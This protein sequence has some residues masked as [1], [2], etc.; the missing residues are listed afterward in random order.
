MSNANLVHTVTGDI[1]VANVVHPVCLG[2]VL[3]FLCHHQLA[4]GV[5]KVE[6]DGSTFEVEYTFEDQED[7]YDALGEPPG[8]GTDVFERSMRARYPEI[9]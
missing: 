2:T 3:D 4:Y 9:R 8:A 5:Y 7:F 6:H 1:C